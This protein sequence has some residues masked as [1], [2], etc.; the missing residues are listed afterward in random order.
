M[1]TSDAPPLP[2]KG[3]T[4]EKTA[5]DIV[6]WA[7]I[8]LTS[9]CNQ[10][11]FF[12]YEDARSNAAE[13]G[14]GEI[15]DLLRQ[16]KEKAEQVVLCGKEVLLRADVLEIVALAS[17]MGLRTV[18]FTNGQALA[19]PG[20]VADLAKAGCDAVS[21]SFHFP[22]KDSFG[23]GARVSPKLFDRVLDGLRAVGEHNRSDPDAAISVSTEIDMFALNADRLRKMRETIDQALGGS[24]WKMRL[25]A[26]LPTNTHDI[27]LEHVLDPI[28]S[29]REE[30]KDFVE[31]HPDN[32]PLAFVKTPLCLIPEG[33]EHL[34][35]D[36]EYVHKGT[37][38][39]FNH[40]QPD[41]VTV[42]PFSSSKSRKTS[43]PMDR[44]PYRWICRPCK[45]APMCRFERVQ[46]DIDG[47]HPAREQRPLPYRPQ[48]AK[49]A[50]IDKLEIPTRKA[51]AHEVL[52]RLGGKGAAEADFD[53]LASGIDEPY[54]EETILG[55]LAAAGTD[56]PMLLDAWADNHPILVLSMRAAGRE[57]RLRLETGRTEA[58][59]GAIVGYLS[60]TP[61]DVP[62]TDAGFLACARLLSGLR[63]PPIQR[64]SRTPW[65]KPSLALLLER[66]WNLM[67]EDLWPGVG[68]VGEWRTTG[69]RIDSAKRLV[70]SMQN[71][72]GVTGQ[73]VFRASN[74]PVGI[75][76][77]AECGSDSIQGALIRALED[78]VPA[79]RRERNM[80]QPDNDEK[81]GSV[82]AQGYLRVDAFGADMSGVQY[83]FGLAKKSDRPYYKRVGDTVLWYTHAKMDGSAT[84]LCDLL[85]AVMDS[86]KHMPPSDD[87]IA[88]WR[89][90]IT[91]EAERRGISEVVR[92]AIEWERDAGS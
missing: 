13:P 6:D 74:D 69:A 81:E 48:G 78:N 8:T 58:E 57:L 12:C 91:K 5:T 47:F 17:S 63:L 44:H 62:V 41:T 82:S 89:L 36:V 75:A 80:P 27:G 59:L 86:L 11:C 65:F 76:A 54:P 64:W 61:M 9:R 18:V 3:R 92:W 43:E 7:E 2:A 68:S 35:L 42:D 31:S 22:D 28:D 88:A 60:A 24:P 32:I 84:A 15:V 1:S 72:A 45:M 67:G 10:R 77:S 71:P 25:A 52:E 16:T 46:W 26:L 39:T 23:R 4:S 55:A 49:T 20:L 30:L 40:T 34:S 14:M 37:T 66:A 79:L 33:L 85:L 56:D 53:A 73:L 21:I 87:S 29:R 19:R 51:G 83:G 90:A 50:A 70:V 38:L